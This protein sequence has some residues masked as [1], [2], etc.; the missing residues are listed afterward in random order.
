MKIKKNDTVLLTKGKDKGKTGKVTKVLPKIEKVVVAGLNVAKKHSRPTRKNPRGGIIDL[1]LPLF[2]SNVLIICPRCSK[3]TK[4]GYKVTDK[5][6][7]RICKKCH[8][9]L[10]Q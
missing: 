6:K 4:A 5:G 7:M 9:A 10:D 2:A 3:T 8:E 1:H